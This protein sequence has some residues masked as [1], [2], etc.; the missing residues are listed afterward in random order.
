MAYV[1]CVLKM[2]LFIK[3]VQLNRLMKGLSLVPIY[4]SHFKAEKA[5]TKQST[6]VIYNVYMLNKRF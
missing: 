6:A 2:I 5:R 3:N 4:A 1:S